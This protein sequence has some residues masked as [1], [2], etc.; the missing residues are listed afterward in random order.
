MTIRIIPRLDIKGPNLVKGIQMEGLRVLGRPEDFARYYYEN[1]ADELIY[2][3]IVASLYERNSL[4]DI[5]ERTS[6]EIFIPMTVGG[7]LRTIDD[8]RSVLRAGADKV[9][10]NTAAVNDSDLIKKAVRYFGSSTIVVSIEAKKM[11][12][13]PY[14]TYTD[15]GR[16]KT[17]FDAL[18]WACRVAELGAGEIIVTSIDREGTGCGYDLE[19]T[20]M[21]ADT[22]SIPVIACG[23]AG[24]AE[25]VYDVINIGKADAVC[26]AS[27]FHY[28]VLRNRSSN[29]GD[30]WLVNNYDPSQKGVSELESLDLPGLKRFLDER[31]I[32]VRLD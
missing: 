13:G 26:M 21:I 18:E 5:I 1:G 16:Q 17:G 10:L 3:D 27:I 23:G 15:S 30:S 7:G 14:E 22:L 31:G 19:L 11:S 28:D 32:N 29:A 24:K 25:H 6:R 20:R 8:I 12:N 9:S 2:M 4:N